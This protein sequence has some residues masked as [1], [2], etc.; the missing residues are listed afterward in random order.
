MLKNKLTI[1]PANLRFKRRFITARERTYSTNCIFNIDR[2]IAWTEIYQIT[3]P[4]TNSLVDDT[5]N[6]LLMGG[7]IWSDVDRIENSYLTKTP[8]YIEVPFNSIKLTLGRNSKDFSLGVPPTATGVSKNTDWKVASLYHV[9]NTQAYDGLPIHLYYK[10]PNSLTYQ[11]VSSNSFVT[12]YSL[13][14]GLVLNLNYYYWVPVSTIRGMKATV[15]VPI[16]STTSLKVFDRLRRQESSVGNMEFLYE[17]ITNNFYTNS[18]KTRVEFFV[19]GEVVA[20]TFIYIFG[21]GNPKYRSDSFNALKVGTNTSIVVQE[22]GFNLFEE[23]KAML[24]CS[25]DSKQFFPLTYDSVNA[26]YNCTVQSSTIGEKELQ[27]YARGDNGAMGAVSLTPKY[28]YVYK[29]DNINYEGS[30]IFNVN[31]GGT[32]FKINLSQYSV[33]LSSNQVEAVKSRIKCW[34]NGTLTESNSVTYNGGVG[35]ESITCDVSFTQEGMYNLNVAH[36]NLPGY[37]LLSENYINFYTF[38]PRTLSPSKIARLVNSPGFVVVTVVENGLPYDTTAFNYQFTLNGNTLTFIPEITNGIITKFQLALP[39]FTEE[40]YGSIIRLSVKKGVHVVYLSEI[41]FSIISQKSINL[42][43]NRYVL[44]GKDSTLQFTLN[45]T[46]IPSRVISGFFCEY[47]ST[48]YFPVQTSNNNILSCT[49]SGVG[50]I[51]GRYPLKLVGGDLTSKISV[52]YLDIYAF[53]NYDIKYYTP[54]ILPQTLSHFYAK[55]V[56]G[57]N[58]AAFF[59]FDTS[60]RFYFNYGLGSEMLPIDFSV[61]PS[62]DIELTCSSKLANSQQ[63]SLV[64]SFEA[65]HNFT[66]NTFNIYSLSDTLL[67]LKLHASSDIVELVNNNATIKLETTGYTLQEMTSPFVKCKASGIPYFV[68]VNSNTLYPNVI[69]CSFNFNDNGYKAISLVYDDSLNTMFNLTS[70]LDFPIIN[71]QIGRYALP[72]NTLQTVGSILETSIL[73]NTWLPIYLQNNI[74]CSGDES[75][76]IISTQM[77]IQNGEGK[78]QI[79]CKTKGSTAYDYKLTLKVTVNRETQRKINLISNELPVQFISTYA[80]TTLTKIEPKMALLGKSFQPI[81]YVNQVIAIS[82]ITLDFKCIVSKKNSD[83]ILVDTLAVKNNN[84]LTFIC[85]PIVI[86]SIGEQYTGYYLVRLVVASRMNPN[87]VIDIFN[88]PTIYFVNKRSLQLH[89][90]SPIALPEN[91]KLNAT[92]NNFLS[93]VTSDYSEIKFLIGG[94]NFSPSQITAETIGIDNGPT[95]STGGYMS[96][97]I[98]FK[99]LVSSTFDFSFSSYAFQFPFI[100]QNTL[101]F[102]TSFLNGAYTKQPFISKLRYNGFLGFNSPVTTIAPSLHNRVYCVIG[103]Y[104]VKAS[105]YDY[106]DSNTAEFECNLKYSNKGVINGGTLM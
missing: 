20:S 7:S 39:S 21:M 66:L 73:S 19:S 5:V 43:G 4:S 92:F 35:V 51:P 90:T 84:D 37:L 2:K 53:G 64:L 32:S 54:S 89:P 94:N 14:A 42:N 58:Q 17:D 23:M 18:I 52:N 61:T 56:T 47:N 86:N 11:Q 49:I 41:E 45:D 87:N 75:L 72:T 34:V 83:I 30:L 1:P 100:Q 10:P 93:S 85:Y 15:G 97:E 25:F 31:V 33:L 46:A 9:Y 67:P 95:L 60:I 68:N 38:S 101:S 13:S 78:Q 29:K 50:V 79:T 22:L 104:I 71:P 99:S 55:V 65:Q 40:F 3:I 63:F 96:I 76:T 77:P 44:I 24:Y 62:N 106:I 8:A 57:N 91:T 28:V 36:D 74:S 70:F 12:F 69:T 82:T 48:Y 102:N 26:N 103:D 80:N 59:G 27:I 98:W 6:K 105:Q 88:T 81:F 16:N